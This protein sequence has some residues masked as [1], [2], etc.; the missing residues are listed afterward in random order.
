MAYEA[1]RYDDPL[2]FRQRTAAPRML[3]SDD[4]SLLSAPLRGAVERGGT[5]GVGQVASFLGGGAGF[6]AVVAVGSLFL[7]VM[8]LFWRLW[9]TQKQ[10]VVLR[11]RVQETL[12]QRRKER[13]EEI[14][15]VVEQKFAQLQSHQSGELGEIK[16][17]LTNLA[18]QQL[19]M[20]QI[21]SGVQ[22][23][24][25]E[26][27]EEQQEGVDGQEG[28]SADEGPAEG[29]AGEG[30]SVWREDVDG[31]ED[32]GHEEGEQDPNVLL[33]SKMAAFFGGVSAQMGAS[34]EF[35]GGQEI[36][37]ET[38]QAM[39]S[40]LLNATS[41]QNFAPPG[42]VIETGARPT[43]RPVANAIVVE[44]EEKT[45]DPKAVDADADHQAQDQ[46][47]HPSSTKEEDADDGI[48]PADGEGVCRPVSLVE[49]SDVD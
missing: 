13:D 49:D 32:A 44:E 3:A 20:Y 37:P 21:M 1:V 12:G 30:S 18:N 47:D 42:F 2:P 43:S 16:Q 45:E 14:E 22:P 7:L 8:F 26:Q 29:D 17:V 19:A 6:L 33:A 36:D 46:E 40:M 5:R 39:M 35:E 9:R 48:C 28:W 15:R 27:E 31:N 34:E 38:M 11:D 4:D 24:E 41:G 25:E 10:F 23:A